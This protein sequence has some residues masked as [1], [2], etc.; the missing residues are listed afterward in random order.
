MEDISIFDISERLNEVINMINLLNE[1]VNI[2]NKKL[3]EQ[4]KEIQEIKKDYIDKFNQL[5]ENIQTLDSENS[6]R[7]QD[8]ETNYDKLEGKV[9]EDII[10]H[11]LAQTDF[12]KEISNCLNRLDNK[13]ELNDVKKEI[14]DSLTTY[15]EIIIKLE[16]NLSINTLR[17]DIRLLRE[18]FLT[19]KNKI[20]KRPTNTGIKLNSLK[21]INLS[22]KDTSINS[23]QGSLNT[24]QNTTEKDDSEELEPLN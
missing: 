3:D 20:Y 1:Q 11:K 13:I 7:N 16:T 19:F 21:P 22:S 12:K 23:T 14:N 9:K 5:K 24:Q 8:M 6:K 18:E 2:N 4:E 17:S 15:N 10:E